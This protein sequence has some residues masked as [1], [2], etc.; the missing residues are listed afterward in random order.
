MRKAILLIGLFFANCNANAKLFKLHFEE[1]DYTYDSGWKVAYS[2]KIYK[3]GLLIVGE[4]RW[5][6]TFYSG[7]ISESK[8]KALDSLL[9]LAPFKQYDSLYEAENEDQSSYKLVIP[10]FN[11][12]SVKVFVYGNAALITPHDV[13]DF[14]FEVLD[15]RV[16]HLDRLAHLHDVALPDD[17]SHL[18]KHLRRLGDDKRIDTRIGEHSARG[19]LHETQRVGHFACIGVG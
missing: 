17:P 1:I 8:L 6:K 13:A 11:N 14:F 19:R 3:S 10:N 16:A 5:S 2:M 7:K 15:L 12:D 9:M 4:G 18:L